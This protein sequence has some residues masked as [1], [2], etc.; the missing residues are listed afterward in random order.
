MF[1]QSSLSNAS[2]RTL[3]VVGSFAALALISFLVVGWYQFFTERA[4]REMISR[5]DDGAARKSCLIAAQTASDPEPVAVRAP[6]PPEVSVVHGPPPVMT[7]A[8][9]AQADS[10]GAPAETIAVTE[11][12][13]PSR[14]AAANAL[15]QEFWH[16]SNWADKM[17]CVRDPGRVGPLMRTYYET[18]G[19]QDPV[20]GSLTRS[21]HF[22]HQGQ[23]VLMFVYVS[24]RPGGEVDA[25]MVA[26]VAGAFLLDWESYVG[27][28]DMSF[29]GFKDQRPAQPQLMRVCAQADVSYHGDFSDPEKYLGLQMLSPDGQY[30]FHGYCEKNSGVGNV[31]AEVL[32]HGPTQV[33]LTLHLAFPAQAQPEAPV[34]ITGL[35]ADRWLVLR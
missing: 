32:A 30:R 31:L 3:V 5:L 21:E 12:V 15:L 25:M 6:S 10:Q 35:V 33:R 24:S 29:Q 4:K 17:A 16:A 14:V 9:V 22:R 19:N 27:W 1:R 2:H 26:G 18:Q 8:E 11:P 23:E 20:S 28:G 13:E 34:L 7:L